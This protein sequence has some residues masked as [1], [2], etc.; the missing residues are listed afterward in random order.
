M[1]KKEGGSPRGW[2]VYRM[3]RRVPCLHSTLSFPI[4]VLPLALLHNKQIVIKFA[5][6]FREEGESEVGGI[7]AVSY[8]VFLV[9]LLL[10]MPVLL[11]AL[12]LLCCPASYPSSGA[13]AVRATCPNVQVGGDG[14]RVTSVKTGVARSKKSRV[15]VQNQKI[16]H[17]TAH[18]L[19]AKNA[20]PS[21]WFGLF[22]T[23]IIYYT[24]F[25]LNT[26]TC[27]FWCSVW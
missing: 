19:K 17:R 27:G 12:L 16:S 7:M 25:Y 3:C 10:A 5:K 24:I 11:L 21:A 1:G 6:T 13:A 23:N 26:E 15:R 20:R 4:L 22:F 8:R 2:W 18:F 9:S 14:V